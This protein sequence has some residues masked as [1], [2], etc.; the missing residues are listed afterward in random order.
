MAI[1]SC[2]SSCHVSFLHLGGMGPELFEPGSINYYRQLPENLA[3][4]SEAMETA[5]GAMYC[6]M[7]PAGENTYHRIGQFAQAR[8]PPIPYCEIA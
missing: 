3:P 8:R 4:K 5:Y 7:R 6:A 1:G 2:D